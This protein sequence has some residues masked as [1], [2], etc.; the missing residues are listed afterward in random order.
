MRNSTLTSASFNRTKP[1]QKCPNR[2]TV[3]RFRQTFD[4]VDHNLIIEKLQFFGVK[5]M[6]LNWFRDYLN[7]RT[8]RVVME[9]VCSGWTH[10]TSGVP[11]GSILGPLLFVIF[12][13]DISNA[14]PQT[15]KVALYADDTKSFR[16]ITSEGD[17]CDLQQALSNLS[18]WSSNN[19]ISFNEPKCKTMTVTR[20]YN[21]LSPLSIL[22][23]CFLS[24][25]YKKKK[26]SVY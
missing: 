14:V 19:N 20:K 1:R 17:S 7:N 6:V 15:T 22:L 13:N 3:F 26:I 21:N 11:Q 10:V 23:T 16:G 18:T 4:S 5:G 9:G 24:I 25:K 8:Q 2:Y 12:I